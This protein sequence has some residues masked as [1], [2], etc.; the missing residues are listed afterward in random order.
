MT[1]VPVTPSPC[2]DPVAPSEQA[3]ERNVFAMGG[4]A[5]QMCEASGIAA[6]S[7][8]HPESFLR[9]WG[10]QPGQDK[11]HPMMSV[12]LVMEQCMGRLVQIPEVQVHLVIPIEFSKELIGDLYNG[13]TQYGAQQSFLMRM[14]GWRPVEMAANAEGRSLAQLENFRAAGKAYHAKHRN[15]ANYSAKQ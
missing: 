5:F 13:D 9:G 11:T 8:R 14:T 2:D 15:D 6:L 10:N 1:T 12:A 7:G 3:G 4:S